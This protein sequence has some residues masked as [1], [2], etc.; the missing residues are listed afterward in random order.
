MRRLNRTQKIV[1]NL[2]LAVLCALLTWAWAGFPALTR[3]MMLRQEARKNLVPEWE[4]VYA[5]EN[6]FS[7]DSVYYKEM[8]WLRNGDTF[9]SVR[10]SG[11]AQVWEVFLYESDGVLVMPS[12]NEPGVLLAIG[13]VEAASAELTWKLRRENAVEWT[14]TGQRVEEDV[15][16]FPAPENVPTELTYTLENMTKTSWA[17]EYFDYTLR[18]YD[19]Q[20]TLIRESK[21]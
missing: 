3:G 6:D 16:R 7:Q 18:L 10:H 19:A 5:E 21:G 20:G 9:W 13:D 8:I 12:M 2:C 1:R 4:E 15:F 11:P 17:K 14:M